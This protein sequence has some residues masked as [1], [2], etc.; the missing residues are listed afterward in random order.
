MNYGFKEEPNVVARVLW[1]AAGAMV[2]G[3]GG[4]LAEIVAM[5]FAD[6]LGAA[7]PSLQGR[8]LI[9]LYLAIAAVPATAFAL[10]VRSRKAEASGRALGTAGLLVV[11]ILAVGEVTGTIVLDRSHMPF[12]VRPEGPESNTGR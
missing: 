3:V 4:F 12:Y 2:G 9:G 6:T 1:I 7:M 11:A 5:S 10:I 8:S